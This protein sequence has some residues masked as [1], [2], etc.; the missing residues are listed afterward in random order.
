M[1]DTSAHLAQGRLVGHPECAMA[2]WGQGMVEDRFLD[3]L[4]RPVGMES[5]GADDLVEHIINAIGLEVAPD[6]V[7]TGSGCS[8]A[9]RRSRPAPGSSP[10]EL[11]E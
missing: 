1:V 6:L 7:K 3:L 4:G 2:G 5:P 9:R 10:A 8:R 11:I